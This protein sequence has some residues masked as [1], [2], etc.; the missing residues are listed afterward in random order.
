MSTSSALNFGIGIKAGLN[1]SSFYGRQEK[2]E[3]NRWKVDPYKD[4]IPNPNFSL[5]CNL[6]CN[7]TKYFSVQTEVKI[8]KKGQKERASTLHNG[9]YVTPHA[10]LSYRS[11]LD[12]P[13]IEIPL[14]FKLYIPLKVIRIGF[15][16]G[17]AF[18]FKYR[19]IEFQYSSDA[20]SI[21]TGM[22]DTIDNEF[23][24]TSIG[25]PIGTNVELKTGPGAI[26]ADFR[27]QIGLTNINKSSSHIDKIRSV[28][29]ALGYMYFFY[30]ND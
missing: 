16:S 5:D 21:T 2:K 25:V 26:I 20:I 27:Y 12:I 7:L 11:K 30:K 4:Q 3:I 13:Y 22:I 14:L 28:E 24:K 23:R 15:Y 10:D 1:L 17:C 6:L 9:S 8:T 18:D 19:K 29:F